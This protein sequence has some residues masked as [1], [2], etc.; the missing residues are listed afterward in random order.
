M[1]YKHLDATLA[2]LAINGAGDK[3]TPPPLPQHV[4]GTAPNTYNAFSDGSF[5][6]PTLP[7]FGLISA[8][9]WWPERNTEISTLEHTHTNYRQTPDGIDVMGY[10]L[11]CIGS[12]ARAEM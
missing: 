10:H 12:S 1:E 3:F 9:V 11:G 6:H 8:G 5:T 4:Q 7:H 2:M